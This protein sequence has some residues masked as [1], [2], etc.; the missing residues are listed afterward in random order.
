[1]QSHSRCRLL[2]RSHA[3]ISDRR[4]RIRWGQTLSYTTDSK[5]RFD[6][7]I[8]NVL[9]RPERNYEQNRLRVLKNEYSGSLIKL[10]VSKAL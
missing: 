2:L 8:A 9:D 5:V 4:H 7:S 3:P 6:L 1:M 10:A